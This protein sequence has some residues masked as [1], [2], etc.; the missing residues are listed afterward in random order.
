VIGWYVHHH[1]VGHRRRLEAVVPHLSNLVTGLGS[2][3][4]PGGL[5]ASWVSLTRDDTGGTAH[6]PTAGGVFHWAP[7]ADDG[8]RHRMATLAAWADVTDC[9]LFVVDGSVDVA[10]FARLLGLPTV[11]LA[12]RGRREDRP[13]HIAHDSATVILA[14]WVREAQP[15]WPSRWLDKTHWVGGLS[16]Y[17]GR[18]DA[19]EPVACTAAGRCA[20]LLLGTG[21]HVLSA[22]D[23]R[24]AADATPGWH[25][26]VAGRLDPVAHP[27]V[28]EHGFVDDV[29]SLLHHADVVVGP[30]G[31][32]VVGEVGAAG[33]RFVALPQLRPF[34]EQ[35]DRAD[36]LADLDLLVRGPSRPGA[37]D[38]P[39]L[40]DAALGLPEGAWA[41]VHDGMGAIRAAMVLDG[42]V[43]RGP[44][45]IAAP[46]PDV[47]ATVGAG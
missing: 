15:R 4:A 16:R 27:S 6:D 2:G 28:T 14:P 17:D 31:S 12:A 5:D 13:H 44:G 1:G 45:P 18:R 43:D 41:S 23:V 8:M 34:R 37:G 46:A 21:G 22:A 10:L 40:L 24:A 25:W 33:A 26:H 42:L 32:G 35:E 20:L 3:E 47:G 29:W 38:W 7:L 19:G 11:V 9:R 39:G 36:H 30:C